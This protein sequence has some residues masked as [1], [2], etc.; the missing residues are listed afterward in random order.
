MK[1]VKIDTEPR[2]AARPHPSRD[3]HWADCTQMRSQAVNTVADTGR[4]NRGGEEYAGT[5]RKEASEMDSRPEKVPTALADWSRFEKEWK[6]E[7]E[8][9]EQVIP[10]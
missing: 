9:L 3:P 8:T 7:C 2:G 5:D 1:K 6:G 4:T 10:W